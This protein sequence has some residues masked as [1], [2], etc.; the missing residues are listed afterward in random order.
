MKNNA[1]TLATK[2]FASIIDTLQ[3]N[4][5]A[6]GTSVECETQEHKGILDINYSVG[7]INKAGKWE[8]EAFEVT[9]YVSDFWK[10]QRGA[11]QISSMH[12]YHNDGDGTLNV[13]YI[14]NFDGTA[15]DITVKYE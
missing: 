5:K 15:P 11:S 6:L 14:D 13:H 4:A 2:D 1:L 9:L 7:E 8:Y 10:K 12:Y 3:A